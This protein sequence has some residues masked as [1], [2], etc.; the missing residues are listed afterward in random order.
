[1]NRKQEF[2]FQRLKKHILERGGKCLSKEY[3]NKRTK[4]KF[5]CEKGHIWED[6][7]HNVAYHDIWCSI[8]RAEKI[9]IKKE[10]RKKIE[11][12]NKKRREKRKSNEKKYFLERICRAAKE[13]NGECLSNEYVDNKTKLEF[14]CEKGHIWEAIPNG[15][16]NLNHWCPICAI[17][18]RKTKKEDISKIIRDKGGKILGEKCINNKQ[19]IIIECS[20][21]HIWT[22]SKETIKTN[23]WCPTCAKLNSRT[24]HKRRLENFNFISKIVGKKKGKCLS[25]FSDYKGGF[26][27]LEFQCSQGHKWKTTVTAVMKGS[28]CSQCHLL[29]FKLTKKERIEG[30]NLILQI[31]KNKKGKCLSSLENYEGLRS[32]LKFQCSKNHIWGTCAQCIKRENWCPIC[33]IEKQRN[34][35]KDVSDL[36]KSKG[37]ELL[38]KEYKS[39]KQKLK[40][41]CKKEHIWFTSYKNLKQFWCPMCSQSLSEKLFR[42]VLEKTFTNYAFPSIWPKWLKGDKNHTLQIDGYN[43]ELKLGFE[44]QGI[45]HFDFIPYFH[46]TIENFERRK[47]N[48]KTKSKIL[49]SRNIFMLYPTYK[50]KKEDYFDYIESQI[51]NTTYKKLAN[52]DQK[53]NI[54]ELYKVI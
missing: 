15:I 32:K 17:E 47:H 10:E 39:N 31:V 46:K 25:E 23:H 51:K 4:M 35:I 7:S 18:K 49:R 3:I 43:K 36:I 1:M 14:Q 37:G 2:Y 42:C 8:C 13:R 41:K 40:I 28:W 24:P 29:S 12:N 53:I 26:S 48:D 21:N 30:F 6:N 11:E 33:N 54:N 44:Y 45:Q 27:K 16:I 19:K 20:Q 38:S 5:Q 52:F 50:L 9:K 34:N 22:T